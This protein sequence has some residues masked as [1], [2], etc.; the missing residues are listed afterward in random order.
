MIL[1]IDVAYTDNSAQVAGVVF[2]SW[3]SSVVLNHYLITIKPIADYESGQFYKRE[4]PC[5]LTLLDLVQEP[6][7][8][9]VIDGYVY[10]GAEQTAGL[11]QH[12]YTVLVDKIPVIGVAKNEFRGTPKEFEI[13]RG[14]SVK[15][16]YVSAIG[17]E[18]AQAKHNVQSMYGKYRIPELLKQVDRLSRTTQK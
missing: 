7:D 11:G 13:L 2:E 16:L 4:L 17:I 3:A 5:I 8:M 15:P 12:L 10:L 9:I 18:L 1:A 6:I 14:Q